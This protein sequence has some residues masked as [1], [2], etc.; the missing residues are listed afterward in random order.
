[1][2]LRRPSLEVKSEIVFS[3]HKGYDYERLLPPVDRKNYRRTQADD[4]LRTKSKA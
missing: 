2:T 4:K 3:S 1:V